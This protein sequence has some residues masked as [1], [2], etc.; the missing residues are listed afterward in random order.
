MQGNF[1]SRSYS[2]RPVS[3]SR[4]HRSVVISEAW[5]VSQS[6]EQLRDRRPGAISPGAG[7]A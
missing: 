1:G 4:A 7:D 2:G 3:K 6:L 5:E